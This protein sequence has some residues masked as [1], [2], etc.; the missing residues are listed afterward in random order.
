MKLSALSSI[1]PSFNL[2]VIL[3]GLQA[4]V[5]L[6]FKYYSLNFPFLV[7]EAQTERMVLYVLNI[8][9]YI[10]LSSLPIIFLPRFFF[11]LENVSHT[12]IG[13]HDHSISRPNRCDAILR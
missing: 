4:R 13:S 3:L 2:S 5:F 9:V 7:T 12:I 6:K 10:I 8:E 1:P 11:N